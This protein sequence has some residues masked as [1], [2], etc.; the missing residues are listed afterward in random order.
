MAQIP[1][2]FNVNQQLDES[3]IVDLFAN[4]APRT[5]KAMRISQGFN[6][7]TGYLS[8]FVENCERADT[9]DNIAM[10][11]FSASDKDIDTMKNKNRSKKTKE[12]KY[13]G[14]K[15]HKDSSRKNSSLYCILHG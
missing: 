9:T 7:G 15:R 1:T 5:H 8:N 10:A 11:K 12:R 14:K 4:K 3:E 6:P 2:L 13:R